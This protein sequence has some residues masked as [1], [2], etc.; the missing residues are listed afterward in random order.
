MKMNLGKRFILATMLFVPLVSWAAEQSIEINEPWIREAPPVAP[1]LAAFMGIKNLSEQQAT[2]IAVTSTH[3]D[4]CEIHQTK[5]ADGMMKMI[6]LP[7]LLIKANNEV[8]LE[9]GSYHLMLM[10]PK[11]PLK[12]G[13]EVDLTLKFAEGDEITVTTPVRKVE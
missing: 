11:T 6:H 1:V 3:F 5:M 13:D 10:K 8:K 2:L 9:P 12:A 4:H 7:Q